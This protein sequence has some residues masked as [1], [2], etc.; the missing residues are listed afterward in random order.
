MGHPTAVLSST[1]AEFVEAPLIDD[2]VALRQAQDSVSTKALIQSETCARSTSLAQDFICDLYQVHQARAAGADVILWIVAALPS[3]LLAELL[4]LTH[5]LGIAVLVET[6]DEAELAI[7]LASRARL[8]GI[9]NRNLHDF[10]VSLNTTLRLGQRAPAEV[11]LVAES[12]IFTAEDI[13][14][15]LGLNVRATAAAW[16]RSWW[17]RRRSPLRT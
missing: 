13:A 3:T 2:A 17:S 15:W 5:D 11:C 6:H 14:G 7:V 1:D 9:N 8:I 10:T 4:A 16:T 12:G